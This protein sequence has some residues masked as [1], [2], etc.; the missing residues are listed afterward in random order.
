M[1]LKL[2]NFGL[3]AVLNN[4]QFAFFMLSKFDHS[5]NIEWNNFEANHGKGVADE[6]GSTVKH[7]VYSHV[8]TN[9][10]AIKSPKQFVEY[11]TE[12]L[13]K[14]TVQNVEN[15]SMELKYQSECREKAKKV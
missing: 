5:I 1:T 14:I 3:M 7:A 6:I 10:V 4:L 2:S 9:R 11:A 13:P 8:L 15:E 12:I